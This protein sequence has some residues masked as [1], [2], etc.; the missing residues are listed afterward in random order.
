MK[1]TCSICGATIRSRASKNN[2]AKINFLAAVRKHMWSKHRNTMISRIKAGK[3]DS[4]DNP[5]IQDFVSALQGA[6][7]R[8]IAVYE[9]LRKRDW[10]KLKKVMD[11]VEPLMP[12]EMLATWK[13]VEA[14]HDYHQKK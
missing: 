5:T 1:G 9:S 3:K 12:I 10:I 14:Y 6:P 11:A 8:A 7:Q 2:T 4:E 13:A